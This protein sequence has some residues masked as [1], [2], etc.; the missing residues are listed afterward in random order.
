[1]FKY[2]VL[3]ALTLTTFS[4]AQANNFSA[5]SINDLTPEQR[6]IAEN[7]LNNEKVEKVDVETDDLNNKPT[8]K[9]KNEKSVPSK[10]I[11]IEKDSN[12]SPVELIY[13][14]IDKCS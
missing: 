12:L 14:D 1:M 9:T 10:N 7:Y 5:F 13:N 11:T 3:F 6:V 2:L 8:E 4:F